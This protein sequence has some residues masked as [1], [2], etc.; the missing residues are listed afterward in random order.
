MN[1]YRV[2]AAA[3]TLQQSTTVQKVTSLLSAQ[4]LNSSTSST[5]P[6]PDQVSDG[7]KQNIDNIKKNCE[8]WDYNPPLSE[9]L[10]AARLAFAGYI[11]S[12]QGLKLRNIKLDQIPPQQLA[13]LVSCVTDTVLIWNVDG[14]PANIIKSARCE[15]LQ[16]KDITLDVSQTKLVVEALKDRIKVLGIGSSVSLDFDTLQQYD[17]SGKC[18]QISAYYT[19]SVIHQ[20]KSKLKS[21]GKVLGWKTD[22]RKSHLGNYWFDIERR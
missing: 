2:S 11:T 16:F 18:G 15:E 12:I 6:Q 10:Q 13:T 17:G 8:N 3:L 14:D 5:S 4:H 9:I 20:Y 22:E 1:I 21:Y 19:P 7:D